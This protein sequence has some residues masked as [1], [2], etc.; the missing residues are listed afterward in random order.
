MILYSLCW[1]Q[2]ISV[3]G[4]LFQSCRFVSSGK[5]L[6]QSAQVGIQE[7]RAG[8]IHGQVGQVIR[9]SVGQGHCLCSEVGDC[10][11]AELYDWTTC[12]LVS[13]IRQSCCLCTGASWI[14]LLSSAI[15][16]GRMRF[17]AVF[18]GQ[19]MPLVEL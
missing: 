2:C 6:H 14:H 19:V 1:Y 18:C 15:T 17:Q 4:P 13:L 11:L 10:M 16:S 7:K 3:T 9:V 5:G 8:S 12:W